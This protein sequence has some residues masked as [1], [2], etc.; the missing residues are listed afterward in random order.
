MSLVQ[1]GLES[2]YVLRPVA[3]SGGMLYWAF[4]MRRLLSVIPLA[5]SLAFPAWAAAG[6]KPEESGITRAQA[7]EILKE[8]RQI[9][10][11]LEKNAPPAA[12]L[13]ADGKVRMKLD[14]SPILGDK[15]APLTMVEFT[16]FQ[17][18]FCQR[19]H[20]VTFAE[21][22]KKYIDTGRVRFVSRDL[23]MDFHS[24]AGRAAQA[25]RCAGDQN[26]FWEMR[27]L[28][29]ANAARLSADD[30]NGFAQSLKLDTAAFKSCVQS[31]K[32]AAAVKSD[33]ALALSLRIDGTP[34][35]IVGKST[36]EGVEGTV[37]MGALPLEAFEAKFD[38]AAK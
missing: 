7:D 22:R 1:T 31:G 12:N 11:L 34:G 32:Y 23:P 2:G 9:R 10:Q 33:T 36:P 20:T 25:A 16:D 37:L 15:N 35:F 24:N 17:C 19:F 29:V 18:A 4:L 6:N 3:G 30:L 5:I 28:L 38:E 21:I 13:D 14:G 8:L 26:R 27:D